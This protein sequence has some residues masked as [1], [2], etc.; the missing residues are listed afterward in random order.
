[1]G[2]AIA[3]DSATGTSYPNLI[4]VASAEDEVSLVLGTM[5][6]KCQRR[7]AWGRSEWRTTSPSRAL[8]EREEDVQG[9]VAAR[10]SSSEE[11]R[12]DLSKSVSHKLSLATAGRRGSR[13]WLR[14]RLQPARSLELRAGHTR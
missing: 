14:R 5:G 4:K 2:L 6:S 3:V 9:V 12:N 10:Q 7:R 13:T 11:R 8:G 1:M